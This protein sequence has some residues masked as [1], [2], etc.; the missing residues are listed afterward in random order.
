MNLTQTLNQIKMTKGTKNKLLL[1]QEN[2]TNQLRQCLKYA[3]DGFINFYVVKVPKTKEL[4][5][6]VVGND[7]SQ[8]HRFFIACDKCSKRKITGNAAINALTSVFLSCE[9]D[10]EQWMRKVLAKNLRIGVAGKTIN[11]VFP[12]LISLFEIAL[13]QK[14][15]AKRIVDKKICVEPKLDGIR[16]FAIVQDGKAAL[17]ARSGKLLQN[18]DGLIGQE[19]SQ[20]PDGCYDGEIMGE[21]FTSLMRQAYRKE[22]VNTE[23]VYFAIFDYLSLNEWETK[24]A[25]MSCELR[26]IM[27]IHA[28]IPFLTKDKNSEL[29]CPTKYKY[30]RVVNR[31]YTKSDYEC[32]KQHHDKFITKGYEGAMVKVLDGVYS[33]GRSFDVM[34]MK[35]FHDID[36]PVVGFKEGTGKNKGSLGAIIVDFNDIE[37][38]VGSGF[39]EKQREQ[40]WK[41][42]NEYLGA[43]A[44]IRYQE[45]TPDMS[46]RFPTF[47]CWRYDK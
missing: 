38:H 10:A 2:E 7:A 24:I 11:T 29:G 15:D 35:E 37:V 40:I 46:L 6:K 4:N 31:I 9:K 41:N 34:K 21:D 36:L 44:E 19:L 18:F 12:N 20:L 30:L 13:A 16:C 43:T 23:N 3:L 28:V 47:V 32:I 22:N 8:W 42:K 14:F 39:D 25:K 33:F 17:Y 27:L 45:V 1:L 5:R 26:Y